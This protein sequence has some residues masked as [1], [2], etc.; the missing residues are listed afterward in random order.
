MAK[1]LNQVLQDTVQDL[2]GALGLA[3]VDLSSG[4]L[5]GV[6]HIVPYFTQN[7]L[8]AV[9]AATVEMFEGKNVRRV[10]EMLCNMRGV[11]RT[12]S[13]INEMFFSTDRTNHYLISIKEKGAVIVLITS[14]DCNQG[15]AWS[16]IRSVT[17]E[18]KTLLP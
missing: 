2:Q 10:E 18:I 13:F 17:T 9:A 5:M 14:K 1:N 15:M 6:H 11:P 8:D 16:K 12:S 3:V 7:Y 4:L